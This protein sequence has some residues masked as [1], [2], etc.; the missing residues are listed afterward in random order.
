MNAII[1]VKLPLGLAQLDKC[2]SAEPQVLSLAL[3]SLRVG[4]IIIVRDVMGEIQ[5]KSPN[6]CCKFSLRDKKIF[7]VYNL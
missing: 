6:Q 1:V 2:Q 5:L 4:D 7:S 3:L